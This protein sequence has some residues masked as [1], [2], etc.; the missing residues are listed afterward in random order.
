MAEV[1]IEPDQ[2]LSSEDSSP[3]AEEPNKKDEIKVQFS[4]ICV[5]SWETSNCLHD[6]S[7]ESNHH[8]E[9]LF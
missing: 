6:I 4:Q 2:K 7:W 1:V 5:K 9:S 8:S 3:A